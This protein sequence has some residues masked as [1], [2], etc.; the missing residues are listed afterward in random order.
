MCYKTKRIMRNIWG[1]FVSYLEHSCKMK[2]LQKD[3][4]K[5]LIVLHVVIHNRLQIES[6]LTERVA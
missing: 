3:R 5:M 1:L 2:I 4:N 6:E